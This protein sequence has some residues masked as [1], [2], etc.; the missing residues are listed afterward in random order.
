MPAVFGKIIYFRATGAISYL[1]AILS[2]IIRQQQKCFCGSCRNRALSQRRSIEMEDK[3]LK[4]FSVFSL[5]FVSVFAAY[6]AFAAQEIS[7]ST[8]ANSLRG[9][10]G[11]HVSY[12]CPAGGSY[13]GRIWGSGL[14][15][16]DSSICLAAVH[17]G[18]I[19]PE[20]GGPVT[21][22][23]RP[24]AP[25]YQGSNRNGVSS[26]NY[27]S[28]HGSFRFVSRGQQQHGGGH[29]YR[30]QQGGYEQ[31]QD[32]YG[33]PANVYRPPQGGQG[34]GSYNRPN[35]GGKQIS[36]STQATS[37]RGQNGLRV[38]YI[39][40]PGGSH[41]GSLWGTNPYTDDSSIC[42]AAVH[43]G[44]ITPDV[45]GAVTIEIKPGA[46]SYHGSNRNGVSSSNYGSWHGSFVVVR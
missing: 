39:C 25:S 41:N 11:L 21:I 5:V 15:T 42:L 29:G 27:G 10:N 4:C 24:G 26:S 6:P 46:G 23:I 33:P 35:H 7:W 1:S 12:F 31:Q 45:G 16:D 36:W 17:A 34:H 19:Q 28:W 2:N 13:S 3:M 30:Q 8:Q 18:R 40:P 32:G 14:Y 22:E 43:T 37:L 9:Q 38:N 20:T 44:V